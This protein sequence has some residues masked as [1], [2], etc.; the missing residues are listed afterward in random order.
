LR[1]QQ[2]VDMSAARRCPPIGSAPLSDYAAENISARLRALAHP[3]RIKLMS[4]LFNTPAGEECGRAL[5]ARI[6]RPETT[7]SHHLRQLRLAGLIESQR[8]G[9]QVYH[10]PH[11]AALSVLCTTLDPYTEFDAA[12]QVRAPIETAVIEASTPT[13]RGPLALP[14]GPGLPRGGPGLVGERKSVR[15]GA[16]RA[17]VDAYAVRAAVAAWLRTPISPTENR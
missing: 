17:V 1:S 9:K 2:E 3:D 12:A 5:A 8:S 10:R 6:G 7:V 14:A 11:R 4:L 16:E 15:G 13:E